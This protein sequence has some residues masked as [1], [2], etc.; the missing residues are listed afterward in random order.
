MKT[1]SIFHHQ[2]KNPTKWNRRVTFWTPAYSSSGT[3]I[4]EAPLVE[5]TADHTVFQ[6][7]PPSSDASTVASWPPDA[8]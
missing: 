2:P 4:F 8:R 6:V 7:S 5:E 1:S 3:V